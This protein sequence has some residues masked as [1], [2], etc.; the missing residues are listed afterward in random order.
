MTKSQD[1]GLRS[2][3][4]KNLKRSAWRN[5]SNFLRRFTS[6]N[7]SHHALPDF[8]IAGAMKCGTTSLFHHLLNH[9]GFVPP[10]R[11][12]I[13][14]FTNRVNLSHGENWY[15]SHLPTYSELRQASES[16]GYQA[17]TGEAT[18][19]MVCNSY[20]INASKLVPK[21]RIVM[22]LRNPID[23]AY[24]HYHHQRNTFFGD[25][26]SFWEA[27]QAEE[28]RLAKGTALNMSDPNKVNRHFRRYSYA[29][30]G[31][32]IDQIEHWLRYFP[33]DQIKI[34]NHQDFAENPSDILNKISLFVG[35]PG[36]DFGQTVHKNKGNYTEPMDERCRDYLTELFR[37][38]NR[39]LYDFLGEDWSWP[40]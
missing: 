24:S 23:R 3:Q 33:R 6:G 7:A 13:H 30:R 14:Y 34:I 26:L 4:L 36:H 16:L 15:R 1:E 19:A 31:M 20:A 8:I 25:N 9:P 35:L 32:Y 39:R 2:R 28:K 40:N 18:P 27:L 11:K 10:Q 5:S 12:E 22:I 38:Y 29:R 37:P 21:A 17:V